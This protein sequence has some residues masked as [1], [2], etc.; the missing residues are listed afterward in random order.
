MH[1]F[2]LIYDDIFLKHKTPQS[3][4][5]SPER[6]VSVINKLRRTNYFDSFPLYTSRPALKEELLLVHSQKHIDYVYESITSGKEL[7]DDGDTYA[8]KDS[9]QAALNAAGSTLK[10]IDLVKNENY[11]RIFCAVRPPGHHAESNRVM[12]F[13]FFNNVA[14]GARYA[15]SK[16]GYNKVMIIDWDVHHGNGTQEIFYDSTDVF[17]ISLHQYPFYPGTGAATDKGIG[18]G[19][20]FTLNFPLTAGTIGSKVRSIFENEIKKAINEFNPDILFISAGFDA[21]KDDP[22]GGLLLETEDFT[23]LTHLLAGY[24]E[25]LNIPLISVLEGGYNLNALSDSVCAHIKVLNSK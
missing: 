10:A 19:K 3:H 1:K 13:C 15:I 8:S 6:L 24:T 25:K 12:G 16:C 23:Y 22:L 9:L 11:K 5:E 18:N 4:V 20:G 7:L 14:I 21:H 17:F 2:A